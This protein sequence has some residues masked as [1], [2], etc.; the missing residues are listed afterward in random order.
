MEINKFKDQRIIKETWEE[1]KQ[2][3]E[4]NEMKAHLHG[5]FGKQ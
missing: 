1:S 2:L 4:L 5:T 3:L